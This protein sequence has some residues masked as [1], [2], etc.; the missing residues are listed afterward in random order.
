MTLCMTNNG[1]VS[2]CLA[3]LQKKGMVEKPHINTDNKRYLT[4]RNYKSKHQGYFYPYNMLGSK[5]L[6]AQI[7][8]TAALFRNDVIKYQDKLGTTKKQKM[9]TNGLKRWLLDLFQITIY[10]VVF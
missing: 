1:Q 2:S 6:D 10:V 4:S 9:K 3:Q 8:S 5:W 7:K